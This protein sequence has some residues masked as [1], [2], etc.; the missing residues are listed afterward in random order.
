MNLFFIVSATK[1]VIFESI[2]IKLGD[3]M[4]NVIEIDGISK[5][6]DN[7]LA[8]SDVNLRVGNGEIFGLLGPTGAGK[9]TMIKILTGQLVATS[10]IA[11]V[12]NKNTKELSDEEYSKIGMVLDYSGLYER[13]S[14]YDNLLVFTQIYHINKKR[15]YEILERVQLSDAIKKSASSLSKGMRQKLVLVRA[16]LHNP[17]LLFLD[18]PTNGLDPATAEK[19]YELI[20]E[21]RNEGTTVFLTTHNMEEATKM[22]DNVALLN[23]GVIIEYGSPKDICRKYNKEN[24]ITIVCRDNSTV[25]FE[26]NKENASIISKYFEEDKVLAIH[27][28]EPNLETVFIAVT[29]RSFK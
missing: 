17:Q 2:I 9:T 13:L 14:C 18:E 25:V 29:G 6:F 26:N 5:Q 12:F 8:L 1:S 20:F 11:K 10:G 16:I 4:R 21:L 15:I 24:K 19:I 27:S 28:S 23:D 3:N 7:T 22:C